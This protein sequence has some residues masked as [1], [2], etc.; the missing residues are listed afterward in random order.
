MQILQGIT[1]SPGIAIGEALVLDNEGFRIPDRF[2]LRD[3]VESELHRLDQ[4][5]NS[6]A[7]EIRHNRDEVTQQLGHQYGAIFSA[8]LQMLRDPMLHDEIEALIRQQHHSAEYAVS[9]TL[10]RYAKV[11]QQ[12]ENVYMAERAHDVFDLESSL[13][14]NLLGRRRESLADLETP[15]IVLAHNLTPNETARMNP[16]FV[17]S[18]V[19]E[20]GG[21]GSH[22]A[23]IA[24]GLEIP[25]IVG[26][27]LFLADVSGGDMVIV[28][29]DHGQVI[30]HPDQETLDRYQQEKEDHRT[31]AVQLAELKDEPAETIDGTRIE[32]L[33]NIEFPHEMKACLD[34]GAEGIGLYRTEFLYLGAESEPTE[35]DHY[36]AY[37][38]VIRA[39]GERTVVIRTV[40]LG[41]D[42]MGQLPHAEEE[43][44]P[45]L[46]VRSIRLSLRNL[47]LFRVQLRAIARAS[48]L[49]QVKVMFPL[50]ATLEEI[51]QA[52][53]VLADTIEDVRDEGLPCADNIPVGMMVEVPSAVMMIDKLVKEVDFLSIETNDLI[54]YALAVDRSNKD[55][56]SLYRASDPAIL[57]L[58]DVTLRA[59]RA[60]GVHATLCGEMSSSPAYTL[61]LL[62]L[63][64]R[65]MS[66]APSALPE[67]K[68][69]C[70]HVS[71]E[72]CEGIAERVMDMDSAREID[73]YLQEQLRKIAPELVF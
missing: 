72:Q 52:K 34:R 54:Q 47:D 37:A 63:G 13:L 6:V 5:I 23:I 62:G 3:A 8:H 69:I 18:F 59:A 70:R 56:A 4:A 29:G 40:D 41:A 19:T 20:A 12:L 27:G 49:G 7:G 26:T 11:F 57:R 71:L 65:S 42:K 30:L 46:G 61:L 39:M 9:R 38:E 16:K 67:I 28:D 17:L 51:R 58:I 1:V 33:A 31:L 45:F 25:A 53:M 68:Q 21:P 48:A 64:L 43:N 50:I 73:A 14:A 60:A 55:I 10:R 66:V 32:L 44:N 2:V 35:E 24:K 22:T 15:A 36:Q